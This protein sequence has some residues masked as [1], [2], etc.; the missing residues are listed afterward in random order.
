MLIKKERK[1]YWAP[2]ANLEK[3]HQSIL[4]NIKPVSVL[5]D[6]H[7]NRNTTIVPWNGPGTLF[8]NGY[9]LCTALK[10]TAK[11]IYYLPAPF[12]ADISFND[13]GTQLEGDR[14]D[15]FTPRYGSFLNSFSADFDFSYLF[16]AEESL[17]LNLVP[18]FF[19]QTHQPEY[20]F[21]ASAGVDI[22][23]WF[24]PFILSYQLWPYKNKIYFKANEPLAYLKFETQSKIVFEE[25]KLTSTILNIANACSE[26]RHILPFQ[27]MEEIYQR[28]TL[29]SMKK[30]LLNEIKNNLVV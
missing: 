3:E 12:D 22:S 23:K 11:N 28:F 19:H 30:R 26:H 7:K 16:F 15:W 13:T 10:E 2:L 29:T 21:I 17:I 14:S 9:H 8:G 18:P 1:V 20:G 5:S 27:S 6:I 24:R 25:F 4:L